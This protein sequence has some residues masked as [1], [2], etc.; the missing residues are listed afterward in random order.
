MRATYRI[1][2]LLIAAGVAVQTAAVGY[3][4]F[5]VMHDASAGAV[6][7]QGV[8]NAG[9]QV[10]EVGGT[11][12]PALALL[13]LIVSF[14]VKFPG[15]V[16]WAAITFGVA[17]LQVVL[18]VAGYSAPVLGLLH[19]LNAFA[20][21]AVASLSARAARTAGAASPASPADTTSSVG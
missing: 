2:A 6:Y 11:V 1:L 8:E 14:F 13:L 5:Q 20:L 12:V 7:T 17:V 4:W 18:A 19:A 10:H 16:R 15:G 21:A 3:A 9:H